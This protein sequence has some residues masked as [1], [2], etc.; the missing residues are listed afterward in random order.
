MR[1]FKIKF[2][3]KLQ[4]RFQTKIARHEVQ[5]PLYYSHFEITEF[6]QY[7][8]LFDLIAV[9]L[10]S[11]NKK[12]FASHFLHETKMMQYRAKMVRFKF[13]MT[14]PFREIV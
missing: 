14:T 11:G 2:D 13:E 3:L 5:L 8:Y 9:L 1:D 4:V 6:S 7:Q 12:A 10:K